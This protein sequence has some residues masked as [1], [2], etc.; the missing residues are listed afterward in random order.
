MLVRHP[1]DSYAP[2]I[3]TVC[4]YCAKEISLPCL[5][6]RGTGASRNTT[7]LILHPKCCFALM[8]HLLDHLIKLGFK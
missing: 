4:F 8:N 1:N 3:G 2:E 6:W 7:R 5:V